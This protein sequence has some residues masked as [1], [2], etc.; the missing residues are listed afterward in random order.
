MARKEI[1]SGMNASCMLYHF[2]QSSVLHARE[3]E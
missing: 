1:L 2:A 3:D